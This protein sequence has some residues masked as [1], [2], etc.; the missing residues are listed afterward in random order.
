[1]GRVEAGCPKEELCEL[2]R[3]LK[4]QLRRKGDSFKTVQKALD[5][6]NHDV[7]RVNARCD[8]LEREKERL[9]REH[10]HATKELT[11]ATAQH[12]ALLVSHDSVL[13]LGKE[14]SLQLA[15][16]VAQSASGSTRQAP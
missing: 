7:L 5:N 4:Q 1:M 2:V 12:Q 8:V 14:K 9:R 10:K 13:T 16:I 3:S 6:V 15:E 11:K